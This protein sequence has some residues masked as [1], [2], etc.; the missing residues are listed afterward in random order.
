MVRIACQELEAWYLGEPDALAD[1]YGIDNLRGI[2]SRA[3]FRNPDTVVRPSTAVRQLVPRFQKTDVA[4]RL[5]QHLS[6][7]RNRSPSF[8]ALIQGIQNLSQDM[9]QHQTPPK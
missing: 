3:R 6:L 7:Q 4:R 9:P 2:G 5:A 1:A 8:Q